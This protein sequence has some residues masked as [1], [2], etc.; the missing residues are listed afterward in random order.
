MVLNGGRVLQLAALC[1]LYQFGKGR[2]TLI[3][4]GTM[5]F[6]DAYRVSAGGLG[7]RALGRVTLGFV[8]IRNPAI[9]FAVH[10]SLRTT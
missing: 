10:R 1:N 6:L 7:I 3:D 2:A 4:P 5:V 8:H 9:R